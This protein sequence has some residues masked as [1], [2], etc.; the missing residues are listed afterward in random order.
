MLSKKKMARRIAGVPAYI[1]DPDCTKA[2]IDAGE[3]EWIL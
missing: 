1:Q 2:Q 3:D